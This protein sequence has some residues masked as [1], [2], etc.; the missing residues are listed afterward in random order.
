MADMLDVRDLHAYYGS[1]HI[2]HG[3]NLRIPEGGSVGLLGRNGAGKSTLLKSIMHL[4]PRKAGQVQF[5]DQNITHTPAHKIA[6]LGIG[7]V[8]EDLRIYPDV[9]VLENLELGAQSSG[10]RDSVPIGQI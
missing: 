6:K 10:K 2:L 9:T 1:S 7:F 4:G 8:H 3:I 5:R